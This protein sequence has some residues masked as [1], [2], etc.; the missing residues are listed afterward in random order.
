MPRPIAQ[1]GVLAV[2]QG[3]LCLI[4][5]RSGNR[6]VI[7]K[8]CIEAHQTGPEAARQEAWEEAGLLGEVLPTPIGLYHY[9]KWDRDHEVTVYWLTVKHVADT[10]PEKSQRVREWVPPQEAIHRVQ[11]PELKR[12]IEAIFVRRVD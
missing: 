1:A 7:P 4:T 3:Q 8:G 9:S 11:E 5:S 2:L 6:W 10:W 12:L